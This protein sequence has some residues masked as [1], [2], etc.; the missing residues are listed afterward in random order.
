M[1][2]LFELHFELVANINVLLFKSKKHAILFLFFKVHE[3]I[4]RL[5]EDMVLD[6][7]CSVGQ[8]VKAVRIEV[9]NCSQIFLQRGS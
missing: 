9:V 2:L 6:C 4:G 1:F 8:S 7:R 5:P 3:R